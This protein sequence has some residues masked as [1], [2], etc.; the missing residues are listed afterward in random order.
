MEAPIFLTIFYIGKESSQK[1]KSAAPEH[2]FEP[3]RGGSAGGVGPAGTEDIGRV[4][5]ESLAR[6][7]PVR[8]GG[9]EFIS[10]RAPPT[11]TKERK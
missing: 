10:L 6:P 5:Y 3:F 8:D 11:P 2:R 4:S 1:R 9:G 7:R